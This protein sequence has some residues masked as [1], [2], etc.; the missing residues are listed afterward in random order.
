VLRGW[1]AL[2]NPHPDV[3]LDRTPALFADGPRVFRDGASCR[4]ALAQKRHAEALAA[5]C[6]LL[7]PEFVAETEE[8][9][10]TGLGRAAW[11]YADYP[12]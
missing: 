9:A 7:P 10:R 11:H 8:T 1:P 6:G 3:F 2:Y 4:K 12:P 5:A